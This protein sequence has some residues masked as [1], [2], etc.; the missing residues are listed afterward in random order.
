MKDD[1]W[2]RRQARILMQRGQVIL[3][4]TCP[5]TYFDNYFYLHIKTLIWHT[6]Y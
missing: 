5:T 1:K 6:Q 3:L 4:L 2:G